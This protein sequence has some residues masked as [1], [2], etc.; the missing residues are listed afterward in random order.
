MTWPS[1]VI[2]D[3]VFLPVYALLGILVIFDIFRQP[4]GQRATFIY[5]TIFCVIRLVA[6]AL[7]IWAYYDDYKNKSVLV[8]GYILQGLGYSFLISATLGLITRG[9]DPWDEAAD[10]KEMVVGTS[11]KQ[12]A[13][14][15]L[16]IANIVALVLLIVGYQ[17]SIDA[18]PGVGGDSSTGGSLNGLVK[19]GDAIY[20]VLTPIMF[21][22]AAVALARADASEEQMIFCTVLG[23]LVFM[24]VRA[25]YVAYLVFTDRIFTAPFIPKLLLQYVAEVIPVFMYGVL[26]V[27]L[28][29]Y[30]PW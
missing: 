15:L 28:T 30:R 20:I 6:N 14:K 19:A 27:V 3:A 26:G 29:R 16:N 10:V 11:R 8:W 25:A 13:P 12:R 24:A 7:L 1:S 9:L 23:A 18:F 2:V 17:Y 5:L 4:K 21:L 22:F